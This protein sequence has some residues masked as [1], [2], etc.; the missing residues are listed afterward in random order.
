MY[1]MNIY[2]L[3]G[4]AL[5]FYICSDAPDDEPSIVIY[6][7]LLACAFIWPVLI[8]ILLLDATESYDE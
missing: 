1:I 7:L 8:G 3:I 5:G 4:L 6:Q 2:L